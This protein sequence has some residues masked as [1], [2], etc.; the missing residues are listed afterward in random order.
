MVVVEIRCNVTNKDLD[1][2]ANGIYTEGE[3][4]WNGGISILPVS[5][6]GRAALS[7][8][9]SVTLGRAHERVRSYKN[10]ASKPIGICMT[11]LE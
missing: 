11:E 9:G 5:R 6:L 3:R 2:S 4:D 10:R 1:R 8:A 7:I